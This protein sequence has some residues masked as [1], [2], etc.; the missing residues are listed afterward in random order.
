MIFTITDATGTMLSASGHS[1]G[2]YLVDGTG[3]PAIN[4]GIV[5]TESVPSTTGVLDC[6]DSDAT[7]YVGAEEVQNGLDNN[8]DGIIDNTADSIDDDGDGF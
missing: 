3:A 8:C 6:D 4:Q 1:S 7:V 5:Y 2:T